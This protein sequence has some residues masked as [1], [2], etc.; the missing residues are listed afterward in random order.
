MA[1]DQHGQ[2]YTCKQKIESK[3]LDTN[4]LPSLFWL[5][6]MRRRLLMDI[7]LC[8]PRSWYWLH[9]W[10]CCSDSSCSLV[11][12]SRPR[13]RGLDRIELVLHKWHWEGKGW[14]NFLKRFV[15]CCYLP[16]SCASCLFTWKHCQLLMNCLG[17]FREL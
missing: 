9:P 3:G 4:V 11:V 17:R 7:A 5:F 8:W 1:N 15:V 13:V 10:L 2:L 14:Q 12:F 16:A 6:G